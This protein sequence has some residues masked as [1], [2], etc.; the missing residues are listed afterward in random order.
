MFDMKKTT[1]IYIIAL[2][3]LPLSGILIDIYTPSLPAMTAYFHTQKEY[4]QMTVASYMIG[5]SLFQLISGPLV[6]AFGRRATLSVALIVNAMV[7]FLIP[8]FHTIE[9]IIAIRVLQGMMTAIGSVASRSL[10]IDLY[11]HQRDVFLKK[12]SMGNITWAMGPILAPFIGGYVQLY[13]GWQ[14]NFYAMG[15]YA[16]IIGLGVI[17][18]VPETQTQFQA[19]HFRTILKNYGIILRN[20]KFLAYCISCGPL[21]GCLVL[22]A[23][24]GPFI[25]QTTLHYSAVVF[26][27]IALCMGIAWLIGSMISRSMISVQS[28]RK[29]YVNFVF[30][31]LLSLLMILAGAMGYVNIWL[32]AVPAILAAMS[33]S[34][35]FTN[36]FAIA[37]SLFP[38]EISGSV[39]GI[40]SGL[41]SVMVMLM[42]TIGTWQH[43]QSQLPLGIDY[44]IAML[45]VT[46]LFF[47]FLRA[48]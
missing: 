15:L 13:L 44:F 23:V 17:F 3:A 31:L 7:A 37:L 36:H 28:Y 41:T 43:A 4:V 45:L 34:F 9:P 42:I 10:I 25:I 11:I 6:D 24:M 5:F 26:G 19:F 47:R 22:F 35:I 33:A 1:L 18:F 46:G 27:N 39:N 30:A 2:L 32:V 48:N 20:K 16:L 40:Y 14:A 12:M 29:L 8:F 38:K 21:W